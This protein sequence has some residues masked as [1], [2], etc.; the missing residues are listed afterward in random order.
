MNPGSLRHQVTIQGVTRT[1][2]AG[3]GYTEVP[4]TIAA[5][6]WAAVEPLEGTERIRAMQ[7]EASATHRVRIRYRADVTAAQRVIHEG[8]AL[9]LVSPPIDREERHVELVLLCREVR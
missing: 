3:G 8:R 5:G 6:V 1:D 2:D 4:V 7:T 9:E